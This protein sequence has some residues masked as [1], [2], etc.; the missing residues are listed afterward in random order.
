MRHIDQLDTSVTEDY[1]MKCKNRSYNILALKAEVICEHFH[2]NGSTAFTFLENYQAL[3]EIHN[4]M[5]ILCRNI[6]IAHLQNM[7]SCQMMY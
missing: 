3:N 2:Y 1:L 4:Y 5:K 6:Y 7:K